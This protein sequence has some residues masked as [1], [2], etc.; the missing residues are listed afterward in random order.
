MAATDYVANRPSNL[1]HR[2]GR[3]HMAMQDRCPATLP[4]WRPSPKPGQLRRR[5]GFIDE[6]QVLGVEVRL[7]VEPGLP[8]GG[9]VGPLLLA[10]VR[11]FF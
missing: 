5:S 3:P 9:N 8:P 4:A 11:C 1:L 2:N 10:G 7:R 6:H